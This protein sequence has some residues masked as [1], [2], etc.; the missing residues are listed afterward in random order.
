MTD[1]PRAPRRAKV[2]ILRRSAVGEQPS[3]PWSWLQVS[4]SPPPGYRSRPPLLPD[5]QSEHLWL[6]SA[7]IVGLPD[8]S[9]WGLVPF[10]TSGLQKHSAQ[11]SH[12]SLN[13]RL[14]R[15]HHPSRRRY[16]WRCVV[17]YVWFRR[18]SADIAIRGPSDNVCAGGRLIAR[19]GPG[20]RVCGDQRL[21]SGRQS[22]TGAE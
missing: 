11:D 10:S 17:P 15:R 3:S 16:S 20:E 19:S 8:S 1:T 6:A 18:S 22:G 4:H 14:R 7:N 12:A 9:T 13:R 21:G 5:T 2:G